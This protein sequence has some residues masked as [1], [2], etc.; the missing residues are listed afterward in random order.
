MTRR[1]NKT[2]T[3]R[4]NPVRTAP[5]NHTSPTGF[6]PSKTS[7]SNR[8]I[9]GNPAFTSPTIVGNNLNVR[10][11][12]W[13]LDGVISEQGIRLT[14]RTI[15][16]F[17]IGDTPVSFGRVDLFHGD[18]RDEVECD[19]GVILSATRDI[20]AKKMYNRLGCNQLATE[21]DAYDFAVARTVTPDD[22]AYA[23][24]LMSTDMKTSTI[25]LCR[26]HIQGGMPDHGAMHELAETRYGHIASNVWRHVVRMLESDLEYIPPL[27]QT[28]GNTGH[29]SG[30]HGR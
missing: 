22:L 30:G 17:R 19:T 26:E 24:G 11:G 29:R 20:L 4:P 21:R 15:V 27:T 28:E 14:G 18:P 8:P 3:F 10:Q 13:P 23:W 9:P 7:P 25:D 1:P 2:T 12:T 16:H 5:T 6:K